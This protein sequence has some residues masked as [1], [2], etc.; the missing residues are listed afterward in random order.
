MDS[1]VKGM[2]SYENWLKA[3]DVIFVKEVGA[4]HDMFEDWNWH[5]DYE[6]NCPPQE[7][8]DEWYGFQQPYN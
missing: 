7:S 6:A 2:I 1:R 4:T 8:F 3:L 5:D